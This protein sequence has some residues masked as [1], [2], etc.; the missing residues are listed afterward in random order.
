MKK[1]TFLLACLLGWGSIWEASA[2]M[3][4]SFS[5]GTD[6]WMQY[7]TG[8]GSVESVNM[9]LPT[10]QVIRTDSK[11]RT[12]LVTVVDYTP[13]ATA[14]FVGGP[15]SGQQTLSVRKNFSASADSPEFFQVLKDGRVAVGYSR[16]QAVSTQNQAIVAIAASSE[17]AGQ[18]DVLQVSTRAG[19]SPVLRVGING[20]VQISALV[21]PSLAMPVNPGDACSIAGQLVFS[22]ASTTVAGVFLGCDGVIWRRLSQ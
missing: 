10:K 15:A 19:N 2:Q 12:T 5:T 1:R 7:I 22:R 3:S 16:N 8:Q 18:V 9:P 17:T 14:Q 21:L 6:T 13:P 11:G 20:Q 4:Q